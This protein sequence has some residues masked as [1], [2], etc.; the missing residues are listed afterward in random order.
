MSIAEYYGKLRKYWDEINNLEGFPECSCGA[1]SKCTCSII[2]KLADRDAK[3]KVI[4]FL[5][6]LNGNYDGMKGNILAM[7]PLPTVN[8]AFHIYGATNRETKGN[9]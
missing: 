5:M 2:K 8:K 7:D 4:D 3:N 1:M 9:F 6:G